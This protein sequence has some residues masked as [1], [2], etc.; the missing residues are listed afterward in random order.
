MNGPL[1]RPFH[2]WC[3]DSIKDGSPFLA[4]E[5]YGQSSLQRSTEKGIFSLLLEQTPQ[6]LCEPPRHRWGKAFQ[7]PQRPKEY[8]N[9]E[10]RGSYERNTTSLLTPP[11]QGLEYTGFWHFSTRPPG[12]L[13]NFLTVLCTHLPTG[14]IMFPKKKRVC[15]VPRRGLG[16]VHFKVQPKIGFFILF[17]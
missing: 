12:P 7:H 17:F 1:H 14:S 9:G 2:R 16:V 13:W 11:S 4:P 10:E 15:F 5:W 3:N 6:Q 8:P